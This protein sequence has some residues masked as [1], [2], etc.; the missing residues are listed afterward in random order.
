MSTAEKLAKGI[1]FREKGNDAFR[2]GDLNGALSNYYHAVLHLR[3]LGVSRVG[4]T[5]NSQISKQLVMVYNN[6]AAV[7]ARKEKWQRVL[8]TATDAHKLDSTNSKAKFRMGQA[9]IHLGNIDQAS[10][11]LN[12]ALQ[13][14]PGD[15]VV[16]KELQK[17]KALEKEGDSKLKKTFWGMYDKLGDS[18]NHDEKDK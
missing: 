18:S 5:L 14:N 7:H 6:M 13:E 17:I 11:Y 15:P 12:E 16:L 9:Y 1:E 2:N 10:K 8:E 3:S 4:E